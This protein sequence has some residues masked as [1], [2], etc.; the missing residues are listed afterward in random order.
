MAQSGPWAE[1]F[2]GKNFTTA[3]GDVN[4]PVWV[5][6]LDPLRDKPL[7]ILEIGSWEGRSAIFFLE[8]L[9]NS[10]ITCI[11]TFEGNEE[12][13][14]NLL[15]EKLNQLESRFDSNLSNYGDRCEK[16]KSR[17]IPA[18]DQ[19]AQANRKFD[20]VYIDGDHRRNAVL[21]DSLL[22]WKMV[23][24][25]GLVFWDDYLWGKDYPEPERPKGG[26]D[27]FLALHENEYVLR[28]TGHQIVVQKA[29]TPEARQ[30][31]EKYGLTARPIPRTWRNFV[32][33]LT[34]KPIIGV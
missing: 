31:A 27:A 7:K 30:A 4:F 14:Y 1:W 2:K 11:D 34:R 24:P 16:I 12:Q 19:L 26:I 6:I 13:A 22:C 32:K 21:I 15:T 33:F 23:N 25:G 10:K 5:E 3:W 28:G 9:P 18:L 17:S 20:I 29:D 8:F